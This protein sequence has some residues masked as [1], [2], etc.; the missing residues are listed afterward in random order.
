[1]RGDQERKRKIL[2]LYSTG[3]KQADIALRFE[4]NLQT[5]NGIIKKAEQEKQAS[6]VG[7]VSWYQRIVDQKNR[8]LH[9]CCP[10]GDSRVV[11]K[12]CGGRT[13][14]RHNTR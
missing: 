12:T 8:R 11:L 14:S 10:Q 6:Q 2:E 9:C 5:V 3:Q 4:I 1:M 7:T 13:R